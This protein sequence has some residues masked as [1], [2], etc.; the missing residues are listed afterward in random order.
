MEQLIQDFSSVQ[1][2]SVAV[3]TH[4]FAEQEHFNMQNTFYRTV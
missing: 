4:N 3:Y 1:L 2:F